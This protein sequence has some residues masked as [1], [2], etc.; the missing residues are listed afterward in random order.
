MTYVL[1]KAKRPKYTLL[2]QTQN[3]NLQRRY[4]YQKIF[5]SRCASLGITLNL[6]GLI[7]QS[8]VFLI[9]QSLTVLAHFL[10]VTVACAELQMMHPLIHFA[11]KD[12]C[13]SS[14]MNQAVTVSKH[15]ACTP[16]RIL[17]V[18]ETYLNY[19]NRESALPTMEL[20]AYLKG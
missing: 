9:V 2:D 20:L 3:L 18:R 11:Q 14:N 1:V 4:R 17:V 10:A 8:E 5:R 6:I 19:T 15:A 12:S 13:L 7:I 16:V